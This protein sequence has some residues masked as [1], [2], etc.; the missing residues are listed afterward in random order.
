MQL[1]GKRYQDGWCQNH[2]KN[3]AQEEVR[4]PERHLN[5]LYNKFTS[6]LR[7]GR[8]AQP[9]PIPLPCPPRTVGF[10]VLVLACQ[11]DGNQ[12]FLNRPLDRNNGNDTQDCMRRIPKLKE[13]L[14]TFIMSRI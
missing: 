5:N 4:P 11:E 1:V 9:S 13:P 14:P 10:I 2:E 12:D 8:H 3:V 6:W 7:H